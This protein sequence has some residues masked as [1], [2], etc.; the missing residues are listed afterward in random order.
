M[1]QNFCKCP[2]A[3]I[4]KYVVEH[5]NIC[6]NC[7]LTMVEKNDDLATL[8]RGL[9]MGNLAGAPRNANAQGVCLKPPTFDGKGD[10]KHFF[11]KLS[12]YMET[13]GIDGGG[14]TVRLLKSC[15][16]SAALDLFLSLSYREQ[17][18][19]ESLGQIFQN[20]FRPLSH[21]IVETENL[22]KI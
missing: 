11:V 5:N 21:K 7:N 15:L 16:E 1:E 4:H 6:P 8:L 3:K 9:T 18:N 10:S 14:E 13:Y 19:L 20:H 12:N 2:T 17:S 22:M